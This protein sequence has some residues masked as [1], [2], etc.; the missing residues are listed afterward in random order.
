MDVADAA[1]AALAPE[2]RRL[3]EVE[4]LP[5]P[6]AQAGRGEAQRQG[7][8]GEVSDWAPSA[9]ARGGRAAAAASWAAGSRRCSRAAARSA[10]GEQSIGMG[11]PD[12]EGRDR[13]ARVGAAPRPRAGRRCARSP[14]TPSRGR[15]SSWARPGR[16]LALGPDPA[17][18]PAPEQEARVE[19][20]LGGDQRRGEEQRAVDI[21]GRPHEPQA[22][23]H[24]GELSDRAEGRQRQQAALAE[25]Q[26]RRAAIR[27]CRP[28]SATAAAAG[29]PARR[30]AARCPARARPAPRSRGLHR[31]IS[32]SRPRSQRACCSAL[33]RIEVG[34]AWLTEASGMNSARSP[35]STRRMWYSPSST[36]PVA[37]QGVRSSSSRLKPIPVP[38]RPQERPRRCLPRKRTVSA[39]AKAPKRSA[40]TCESS[41]VAGHVVDLHRARPRAQAPVDRAQ[42]VGGDECSRRRP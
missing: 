8:G 25:D 39:R 11:A 19:P 10:A 2:H 15:R 6:A 27:G 3:D 40:E 4:E 21:R 34:T 38:T 29:T 5:E 30:A 31:R 13:R 24:E 41:R 26:A 42:Q 23:Q 7:Q 16:R 28:R 14:G 22:R 20:H 1:P 18:R 17:A 36:R 35:A 32:C 33:A 37:V 12:R 9:A